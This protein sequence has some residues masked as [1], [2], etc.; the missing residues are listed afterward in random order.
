VFAVKVLAPWL[1]QHLS[2]FRLTSPV[3]N[4]YPVIGYQKINI[5]TEKVML[6]VVNIRLAQPRFAGQF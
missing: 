4:L 6:R 3:K 2:K 1:W 5:L